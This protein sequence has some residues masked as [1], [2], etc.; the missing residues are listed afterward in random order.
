M[1]GLYKACEGMVLGLNIR[2]VSSSNA[3]FL[4]TPLLQ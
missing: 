2:D 1:E 3:F 4:K